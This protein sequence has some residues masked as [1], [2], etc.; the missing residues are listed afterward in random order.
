M[1]KVEKKA[2]S[3]ILYK[4][5]GEEGATYPTHTNVL[6]EIIGKV[7]TDKV[8]SSWLTNAPL[9]AALSTVSADLVGVEM[10][11]EAKN[12]LGFTVLPAFK[13]KAAELIEKVIDSL[14]KEE[15]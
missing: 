5:G 13:A 2:P 15:E 3:K 11:K 6:L 1:K 14:P 7:C 9:K 8:G 4:T 10:G 12:D